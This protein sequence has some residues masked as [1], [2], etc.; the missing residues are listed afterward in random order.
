MNYTPMLGDI[1]LC[2]STRFAAKVVKFLQQESTLWIWLYKKIFKK[3][4]NSVNYYH[5]GMAISENQIVEQQWKVQKDELDKILTRDVIIFR[6]NNLTTE[7]A[8]MLKK[9]AEEDMGKTYDI[10]LMVG[11]TL[12]FVTGIK[13]FAKNIQSKDKEFCISAVADWYKK[14]GETFGIEAKELITTDIMEEYCLKSEDWDTVYL[15]KGVN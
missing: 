14:I 1:F 15:K 13:W 11:K 8:E 10:F 6:K 7:Q 3:E 5:A 4:M 12:T 2:D 9:S